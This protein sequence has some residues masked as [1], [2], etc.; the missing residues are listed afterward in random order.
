MDPPEK[1]VKKRLI[2]KGL[3]L[4]AIPAFIRNLANT[5][6]SNPYIS[7]QTLNSRL[8]FLGWDEFDLDYYTLQLIIAYLESDIHYKTRIEKLS[9]KG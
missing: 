8:H 6:E 2:T 3:E 5:I 7:I 1:I 4:S 9:L